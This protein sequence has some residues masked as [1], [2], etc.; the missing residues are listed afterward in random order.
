VALGAAIRRPAIAAFPGLGASVEVLTDS[1]GIP[2]IR[3]RDD[4]DLARVQGYVQ[5]RD[6]LFQMDWL[7]RRAAGTSA[8]LTGSFDD[9]ALDALTRVAGIR[10]AARLSEAL[11][12]PRERQVLGAFAAGVNHW[13][14]TNPLPR[15]YVRL[16]IAEIPPWEPA[17]VLGALLVPQFADA[18]FD[19]LDTQVLWRYR[20]ALGA[21]QG[22]ALYA[23]LAG[24][25]PVDAAATV[26]DATDRFPF[27][28]TVP[29]ASSSRQA[30]WRPLG[31]S[32]KMASQSERRRARG[33][34]NAWVV[35]PWASAT[36]RPLVATD[37]HEA[38][39]AVPDAYEIHLVV[40]NDPVAGPMDA[41][42]VTRFGLPGVGLAGQTERVAWG[43]TASSADDSDFFL[44]TLVRDAAGC[45][46]RLCIRSEG[47]LHPVEERSERYWRNSRSGL[48]DSTFVVPAPSVDVLTV[49]FR[50]FGPVVWVEDPGVLSGGSAT[51]TAIVTF[52][53]LVR[54]GNRAFERRWRRLRARTLIEFRGTLTGDDKGHW[55]VADSQGGIGFFTSARVPLRADLEQGVVHGDPPWLVRDGAGAA[56]WV[57]KDEAAPAEA[58]FELLPFQEL[59]HAVDPPSGFLL[60]ANEDPSGSWLDGDGLNQHRTTN[61]QAIYYLGANFGVGLRSVRGRD[62]LRSAIESGTRLDVADMMRLQNDTRA[63]DAEILRPFL[64]SAFARSRQTDAPAG[65][66][67]LGADEAVAEAVGRIAAWDLTA[68]TGIPEGWDAAD[69]DGE[70]APD[71]SP[72]EAAA[73]VAAALHNVWRATLLENVILQR[74][75]ALGLPHVWQGGDLA[76]L[77]ALLREDPFD[78]VVSSGIDFFPEPAALPPADRRDLALLTALA[79]TLEAFASAAYAPA[80]GGSPDQVD[81][82]WG[83][84]HRMVFPHPAALFGARERNRREIPPGAGFDPL[85]PDLDGLAREGGF[86]TMTTSGSQPICY[87]ADLNSCLRKPLDQ[88]QSSFGAIW[89]RV[90]APTRD[91]GVH[92]WSAL[93][94]GASLDPE[95]PFFASRLARW[96]TADY[97]QPTLRRPELR[98]SAV[99]VERFV[100]ERDPS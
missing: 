21:D 54:H 10:E 69:V 98:R 73:S 61:P 3:A 33:G 85:A 53:S 95:S 48:V 44:D 49:P 6:R 1:L 84:L 94:G 88:Y 24:Q 63:R 31:L 16:G 96:L 77:L 8:E 12:A 78:G 91:Q 50:S 18:E 62:A 29:G 35:A 41:T 52:Q 92:V 68:P 67:A 83:R 13:L 14:A 26:P 2:H 45:P 66:A 46:T 47:R 82:R 5:A 74:L 22:G 86:N 9:L 20:S 70:R 4:L 11:I 30:R 28:S 57:R 99:R 23:D 19:W 64:L 93:P 32:L 58:P 90:M 59:P 51:E 89:R 42:G 75:D 81:Y 40:T 17:D 37:G 7:R 80:F 38:L 36:G 56:N 71:V 72:A 55:V 39:G 87:S 15:E 34:S 27:L 43:F 76:A 100:P 65:L 97:D 60:N 25:V 79:E